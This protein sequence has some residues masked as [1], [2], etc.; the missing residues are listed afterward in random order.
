MTIDTLHIRNAWAL[1]AVNLGIVRGC[2]AAGPPALAV[3]PSL[4]R[5]LQASD[6]NDALTRRMRPDEQGP[7]CPL[8]PSPSRESDLVSRLRCK[9]IELD[10]ENAALLVRGG[11]T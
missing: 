4:D 5:C 2:L 10:P 7:V 6:V 9:A 8:R 11:A 3:L 1:L